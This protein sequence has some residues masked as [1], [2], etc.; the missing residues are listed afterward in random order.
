MPITLSIFKAGKRHP[1]PLATSTTDELHAMIGELRQ[2]TI[3]PPKNLQLA[4]IN[5]RLRLANELVQ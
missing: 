3:Q 1:E 2:M 5:N 4:E